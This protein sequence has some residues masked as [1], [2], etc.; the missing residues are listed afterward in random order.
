MSRSNT[1]RDLQA[2]ARSDR[3]TDTA[4]RTHARRQR[5]RVLRRAR[6]NQRVVAR[7]ERPVRDP[8][9]RGDASVFARLGRGA[10]ILI[11]AAVVHALILGCFIGA[12]AISK[13]FAEPEVVEEPPTEVSMVDQP[14]PEVDQ[15]P[16]EP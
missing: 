6:A 16:P 12:N 2:P 7:I 4:R 8:L 3:R 5:A 9:A 13:M 11:G 15:P 10:W 14:E 1:A